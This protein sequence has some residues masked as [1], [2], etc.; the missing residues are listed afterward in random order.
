MKALLLMLCNT[1]MSTLLNVSFNELQTMVSNFIDS[2]DATVPPA[3][4]L[5]DEDDVALLRLGGWALFSCIQYRKSA[6][7]G[8]SKI[9]H[10]QEKLEQNYRY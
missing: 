3:S 6:L 1:F 9:K 8:K 4:T 7:K 10:A 5:V 2:I